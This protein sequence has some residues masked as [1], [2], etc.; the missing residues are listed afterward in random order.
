V[1]PELPTDFSGAVEAAMQCLGVSAGDRVVV[2]CNDAQRE[3]AES[4]ATGAGRL[5]RQATIVRFPT[6]TRDGEEPPSVVSDAMRQS[7]IVF[8]PTTFSLSHTKAR[9]EA[10]RHGVRIASLPGITIETFARALPIDYGRLRQLSARLAAEMTAAISCHLTSPV[11]TDLRFRLDRRTAIPDDGDLRAPS[12][13]GNL[14]AGEAYIAPLESTADGTVVFDGAVAG[15]G[16]LRGPLRLDIRAGVIE[17]AEGDGAEWLL[18]TLDAGGP[19]GRKIAEFGIGTNPAARLTGDILE[20]EKVL[21]TAHIAFGNN[22]NFG[23]VNAASVHID[24][25]LLEPTVHLDERPV[26]HGGALAL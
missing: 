10:T 2:V 15:Y 1:A 13:F 7:S 23:G 24:G 25:M 6:F 12:A 8:A 20:D 9:L 11:G 19:T 26:L 17:L 18:S 22:I 3:L 21:G 14:P 4:L 5:A 16:L